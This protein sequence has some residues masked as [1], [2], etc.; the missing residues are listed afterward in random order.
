MSS[1]SWMSVPFAKW[2]L[3]GVVPCGRFA[4]HLLQ[5]SLYLIVLPDSMKISLTSVLKFPAC[6]GNAVF[7][8]SHAHG[9]GIACCQAF[10]MLRFGC[11][12]G[13]EHED[14]GPEQQALHC[15]CPPALTCGFGRWTC[16]VCS[17]IL[18]PHD[19]VAGCPSNNVQEGACDL[20]LGKPFPYACDVSLEHACVDVMHTPRHIFV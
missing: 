17:N 8:G 7:R 20:L 1:S 15:K 13:S 4:S 11:V 5:S 3:Q 19:L 9:S 2:F 18:K 16:P 14:E 12:P 10:A 6:V